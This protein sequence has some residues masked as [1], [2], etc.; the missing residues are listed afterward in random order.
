MAAVDSRSQWLS[1]RA[2]ACVSALAATLVIATGAL[3]GTDTLSVP[4][5]TS[6][7]GSAPGWTLGGGWHAKTSPQSVSV[8][9]AIADSL[10]ILPGGASW[11]SPADGSGVM[12]LADD[13]TGTY[14][15]PWDA[16]AQVAGNGG[17]SQAA[18]SDTLTSPCFVA[19]PGETLRLSFE[20]WW[21]VEAFD[22]FSSDLLQVEYSSDG[23]SNWT[24][25]DILSVPG[26]TPSPNMNAAYS[27]GGIGVPGVWT[28]QSYV[29]NTGSG[30]PQFRFLF[31]SGTNDRNGFRGWFLDDLSIACDG[32]FEPYGVTATDDECSGVLLTWS[33]SS[34][35]NPLGYEVER[36]AVSG[37]A[38]D[39]VAA[40]TNTYL[41]TAAVSSEN[42]EYR[43]RGASP[44]GLT[45]FTLPVLGSVPADP[46]APTG[47]TASAGACDEIVVDWVTSTGPGTGYV[48]ERAGVRIDTVGNGVTSYSDTS[49]A[50]GIALA[51]RVGTLGTCDPAYAAPDTGSRLADPPP[52]TFVSATDNLCDIVR[53]AWVAVANVSGYVVF[54]DSD[55]LATVDSLTT[56]YED[57]AADSTQTY[58]Y[59]VRSRTGCG[60]SDVTASDTGTRFGRAPSVVSCAASDNLCEEVVLTWVPSLDP[61]NLSGFAIL[62]DGTAIDSVAQG[63]TT[64]RDSS[65]LIDT[66]LY[67]EVTAY[68][69]CGYSVTACAD[70][71]LRETTPQTPTSVTATNDRCFDVRVSW[72]GVG[73]EIE[74]YIVFRDD[75]S[76]ATIDVADSTVHY[77]AAIDSSVVATYAVRSRSSCG[78]SATSVTSAGRRTGLPPPARNCIASDSLCGRVTVSW[79]AATEPGTVARYV[80]FRGA[81]SIDVKTA[82]PYTFTDV[83]SVANVAVQ[84]E[85]RT[86]NEC[87]YAASAAADTGRA[88]SAPAAPA[89]FT[90]SQNECGIVVL[91]WEAPASGGPVD[92]YR[93]VR[94][95]PQITIN[96]PGDSL[97]H[98]DAAPP[99][100]A[101]DYS[102]R[103]FNCEESA[104][105]NATGNTVDVPPASPA[106]C[107]LEQVACSG[108]RV[109]WDASPD[110][111]RGYII[112]RNGADI[113]SLGPAASSY[114]DLGLGVGSNYA[115][116]IFSVN[117]CG[118]SLTATSASNRLPGPVSSPA[119]GSCTAT[120]DSCEGV[121][122][123]WQPAVVGADVAW[124][125]IYDAGTGARVD[126]IPSS[127]RSY[128]DTTV[129]FGDERLY[130]IVAGNDC[131]TAAEGCSVTG[132]RPVLP[133]GPVSCGASDNVCD[134]IDVFWTS[135]DTGIEE[136]IFAF[137]VY[138]RLNTPSD[139]FVL[140]H[141]VQPPSIGDN[142]YSDFTAE[143]GIS[144]LYSIASVN[145]CGETF[146]GCTISGRRLRTRSGPTLASPSNAT[147]F[148]ALP[149]TLQWNTVSEISQFRVELARDSL[150]TDVVRDTTVTSTSIVLSG[151]DFVSQ[152]W[153]RISSVNDCGA[154]TP[155]SLRTFFL[156]RAPGI[157][158]V[159]G[160][161]SLLFGNGVDSLFTDSTIVIENS[162][163]DSI[164]WSFEE[165][166]GWI[167]AEPAGGTLAPGAR[168]TIRV[169]V[170]EY[171]CGRPELDT[172]FVASSPLPPGR[173]SIPIVASLDPPP[174]P[175]GDFDWNC[176]RDAADVGLLTSVILGLYAPSIEESLGADANADGRI[177]VGDLVTLARALVEFESIRGVALSGDAGAFLLE[178]SWA[179]KGANEQRLRITAGEPLRVLRA[180][181]QFE[182]NNSSEPHTSA[183][184]LRAPESAGEVLFADRGQGRVDILWYGLD[185]AAREIDLLLLAS[186]TSI[187][188]ERLEA[189]TASGTLIRT[190]EDA[191]ILEPI[192]APSRMQLSRPEPNPFARTS[193]VRFALPGKSSVR[194]HVYDIRGRL[195]R[196][197]VDSELPAGV[198]AREWNGRGDNGETLASGVYFLRLESGRESK[199]ERIILLR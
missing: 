52:V 12:A 9:P 56:Q 57:A 13:A 54:R 194:L 77:D 74:S 108:H 84:Y 182:T 65:S 168:D 109:L 158:I 72:N 134:R 5:A 34:T 81:D 160:N 161:D 136:G 18:R 199:T 133:S 192:V 181:V 44:C 64:Y 28:S 171:K 130:A 123:D 124:F 32:L 121:W 68:N 150:F 69:L 19:P 37:G 106:D 78:L 47:V 141:T 116:D 55:S 132:R 190:G 17:E 135:P 196:T 3:A 104:S 86:W 88:I 195:Q 59:S 61:G 90:A 191:A 33:D 10:V 29:V 152:Y 163:P 186:P 92:G 169:G 131:F 96:V 43:V 42:Y 73:G 25:I 145:K 83:N 118:R 129:P 46:D 71:G 30:L 76:I 180:T 138:R 4:Y 111:V 22:I 24:I 148:M 140:I 167:V 58:A 26:S 8:I 39:T 16:G 97:R 15:E 66:M 31:R 165:M 1:R 159:A 183:P 21:E 198:H 51:Y 48:I 176:A 178:P 128:L 137:R 157:D 155:S 114:L 193:V 175:A 6:F 185:Q 115:Y 82:L 154:G 170:G 93:I 143:G 70:S 23:G 63:I 187:R 110:P 50:G 126:S 166:P 85:V 113:D 100:G 151:L 94:G 27:S 14:I 162:A 189:L 164:L 75:D 20:T 107:S 67:Y 117:D 147:S 41:D 99:D 11:P 125:K 7:E 87:G 122:L 177:G 156:D 127:A 144:Y 2:A 35:A 53:V 91:T 146:G 95:T 60:L 197:L 172:F 120:V 105:V 153:W 79:E 174:R 102:L 103:A 188:V 101:I 89:A 139:P 36:R 179:A 38:R 45:E 173:E 49:S 98:V 40:L 184:Q 149:I 119:S 142:S 80:L 112:R 62:R